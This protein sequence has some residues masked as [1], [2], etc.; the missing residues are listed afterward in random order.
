MKGLRIVI[1]K[2]WKCIDMQI[3]KLQKNVYHFY[4]NSEEEVVCA[5]D[6][7]PWCFENTLLIVQRWSHSFNPTNTTFDAP[8]FWFH[9]LGLPREIFTREVGQKIADNFAQCSEIQ[10]RER[11]ENGEKFFRI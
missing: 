1:S 4:L 2:V 5:M 3:M 8:P 9:I 6:I 10:I 7:G 11:D